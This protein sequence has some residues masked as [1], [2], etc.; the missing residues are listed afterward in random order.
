MVSRSEEES[1][2]VIG[3]DQLQVELVMLQ[4]WLKKKWLH[5]NP[6]KM[7]NK[8]NSAQAQIRVLQGVTP[9]FI[10]RALV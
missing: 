9:E 1:S 5:N 4:G 2:K 8:T 7:W 6:L 10:L 3:R